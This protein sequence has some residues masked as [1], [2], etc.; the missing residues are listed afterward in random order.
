ME[1][2][3][4]NFLK[5][6]INE[7]IK[8]PRLMIIG[9]LF[10][11]FAVSSPLLAKYINEIL[12]LAS[13]DIGITLP[14]PTYLDSWAQFYKNMT[15]ICF[16]VFLIIM[17]GT[18]AQEK[19]KGSIVLVLTKKVSRGNFLVSKYVSGALLFTV[20]FWVA[21][22]INGLY[23]NSLFGESYY[24]GLISSLVLLWLMG[25]FFTAVAVFVSVIGKSPTVSALFGFLAFT[26]ISI[27]NAFKGFLI[28]NPGGA[29]SLVNSILLGTST[30]QQ[31]YT[32]MIATIIG[33]I[34]IILVSYGIFRKQEI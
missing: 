12:K 3:N 19:S 1:M 22:L 20:C 11:F 21:A 15:S 29:S 14:D 2:L 17:T 16:I 23:T 34:V 6:E 33:T 13:A 27:F 10:I 31:I 4:L 9:F 5:K 30:S 26:I 25:L 18:V 28:Y 32:N 8:T 7:T 24:S